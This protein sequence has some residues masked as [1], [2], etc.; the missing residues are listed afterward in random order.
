MHVHQFMWAWPLWFRRYCYFSKLAKISL[1]DHGLQSMVVK[2]LN[3][4]ELAQK[5][6]A[7][8]GS[9]SVHV[10]QFLW[11]WP[12][13][14]R[15]YRYFSKLAQFP[16]QTYRT[17][18]FIGEELILAIGDFSEYSPILNPPTLILCHKD[19]PTKLHA[20]A[21]LLRTRGWNGRGTEWLSIV[22]FKIVR[23]PPI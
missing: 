22:N 19:A 23:I 21:I 6:H 18:R 4:I 20:Y 10:H 1:S 2:N 13:R 14:F 7:S 5:I 15:R 11:A 17:R 9:C 3:Q 8:R 16:F 12:F